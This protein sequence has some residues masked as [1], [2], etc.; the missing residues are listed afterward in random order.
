[1]QKRIEP[2]KRT[3]THA[4]F[5]S[6][7]TPSTTSI[8]Q[9]FELNLE[10][11]IEHKTDSEWHARVGAYG[12]KNFQ[13]LSKT[14][15]SEKET[16]VSFKDY[17][18]SLVEI[19]SS[20]QHTKY[21][22]I[23]KMIDIISDV[24]GSVAISPIEHDEFCKELLFQIEIALTTSEDKFQQLHNN[25]KRLVKE[26]PISIIS[27]Y[28][29]GL[30]SRFKLTEEQTKGFNALFNQLI[31]WF[32][33]IY[34]AKEKSDQ[35]MR[36]YKSKTFAPNP[37][38]TWSYIG[39]LCDAN[40]LD[41]QTL[42]VFRK[43]YE[44]S[45]HGLASKFVFLPDMWEFLI[46]TNPQDINSSKETLSDLDKILKNQKSLKEFKPQEQNKIIANLSKMIT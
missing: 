17:F 36:H 29:R 25:I 39:V 41:T 27:Q 19:I 3:D 44:K 9:V 1:M 24:Y 28:W 12:D 45:C 38:V 43:D 10:T 22:L 42:S 20:A 8:K 26:T 16:R 40:E 2:E 7:A 46:H 5:F 30:L 4:S 34:L 11:I 18:T 32:E 6:T 13:L 15:S 21:Q 31:S 33:Q 23:K 14:K 37:C 35:I